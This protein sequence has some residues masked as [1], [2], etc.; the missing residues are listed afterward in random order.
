MIRISK[1]LG[2]LVLTASLAFAPTASYAG[3]FIGINV[4]FAPPV[5]PVY[6][7]PPCPAPDLI[8]TPGY[9]AYSEDGGYYWV[10][11]AWVAAPQVGYLWTPGY[12]GFAG[13]YYAW[14]PGYWGPHVGFYGGV[15]YGFGY[16][17]S[18]FYGGGW[19]G[20]HYRYNTAY[21]NVNRTV[22]NNVYVNRTTIVNNYNNST[23]NRVSYNGGPSGIQARPTAQELAYRGETHLAPT[24]EQQQHIE[25]AAHDRSLQAAV[26]HG[27][28]ATTT[29]PFSRF[30]RTPQTQTQGHPTYANPAGGAATMYRGESAYHAPSAY[31]PVNAYRTQGT[32]HPSGAYHASQHVP[33]AYHAPAAQTEHHREP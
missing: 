13:G 21:A 14:H 22:I 19:F 7:Q 10:P 6:V 30:D 12:W 5:L 4:N 18:G 33:H 9:W 24:S 15:N 11:G 32:Y 25:S 1:I 31:H 20:N 3:V 26:N 28:P 27:N 17:G 23:V 8:W 29:D 2:A 16:F